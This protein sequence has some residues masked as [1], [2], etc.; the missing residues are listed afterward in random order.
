MSPS[1]A[2]ALIA[3]GVEGTLCALWNQYSP[4]GIDTNYLVQTIICI[5]V[6]MPALA[7]ILFGK[8]GP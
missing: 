3:L 7:W 2:K 1:L 8:E 6:S 5:C 4:Y